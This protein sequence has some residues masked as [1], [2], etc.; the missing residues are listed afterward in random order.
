MKPP[1]TIKKYKSIAITV[2]AYV[3]F[4]KSYSNSKGSFSSWTMILYL[5][6][7]LY[8]V[9]FSRK[10][11]GP[12]CSL[13]VCDP[14]PFQHFIIISPYTMRLEI[15]PRPSFPHNK[16]KRNSRI[17]SLRQMAQSCSIISSNVLTRLLISFVKF[18]S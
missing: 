8:K 15:L 7:Y 17:Y 1:K 14:V 10:Q 6:M 5:Y 11:S 12:Q 16:S 13:L 9:F 4:L 18:A 2:T 3:E